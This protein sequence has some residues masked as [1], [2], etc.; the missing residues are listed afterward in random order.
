[1]PE[2]KITSSI[3]FDPEIYAVIEDVMQSTGMKFGAAVRFLIK[4]GQKEV[5]WEKSILDAARSDRI[6][7]A[8][9]YPTGHQAQSTTT[10][11]K[12]PIAQ[13]TTP[14]KPG[15]VVSMRT[16]PKNQ[17]KPAEDGEGDEDIP[18]L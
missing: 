12:P 18:A 10:P 14:R 8:I 6:A 9:N 16:L 13:S 17:P 11:I 2:K 4:K 15:T 5:E 1:M 7:Q 3:E